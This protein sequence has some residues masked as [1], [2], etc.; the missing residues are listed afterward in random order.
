M[1]PG[2]LT[3]SAPQPLR[4]A[5][6]GGLGAKGKHIF[7]FS[8]PRKKNADVIISAR[9]AVQRA[10][11]CLC[12]RSPPASSVRSVVF[13]VVSEADRAPSLPFSSLPSGLPSSPLASFTL[14]RTLDPQGGPRM[15]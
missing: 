6:G 4:T 12:H 15:G 1:A 13:L 7:T 8:Q 10:G 2:R 3:A 14:S 9:Q 11:F 5:A